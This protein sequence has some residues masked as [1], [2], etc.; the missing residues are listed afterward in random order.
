MKK[1]SIILL[2]SAISLFTVKAQSQLSNGRVQL[3]SGVGFSGWGVP[4]YIGLD[5]GVS[6][7]ITL[8]FE[9]SFRNYRENYSDIKY[10]STIFGISGNGNY[11]FN[12][13]LEIPSN[14]DFYAGLNLGFYAWTSPNDYPGEG[15]SGLGL[16]AQIGGRYFF[17][18]R[19]GLNLEAGGGNA[20][21]GGKF[22][23]TYVF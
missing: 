5:F 18:D 9:G 22:G 14:W 6:R 8:G 4:I 2:L 19:F 11:H 1:L 16:G 15:N 13:V 21:S 3:N 17:N 23:I 20:F 12:R 7:D 10:H